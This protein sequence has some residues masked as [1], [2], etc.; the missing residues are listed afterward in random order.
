MLEGEV[1]KGIGL[2]G[3]PVAPC[4]D[5]AETFLPISG[6]A[7]TLHSDLPA[8]LI[9]GVASLFLQS[10]HPLAMAGVADHSDYRRDPLGRLQRTAN[11]VGTVTYASRAEAE[12]AIAKIRRIH[13]RVVGTA[14]DG[15]PYAATDGDLVTWVH[16]SEVSMF[17]AAAVAYGS[18]TYDK[19]FLDQYVAELCDQAELLGGTAVPRS[20]DELARYFTDIQGELQLGDQARDVRKFLLR[21]VAKRPQ[22]K[23]AYGV[24]V[25]AAIAILPKWARRELRLPLLPLAEPL[26]IRPAAFAFSTVLRLAIQPPPE[27]SVN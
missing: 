4:M 20:M 5:E 2:E 17:A 15:R 12:H 26:V 10:L 8:M 1:R 13:T 9:G 11:Y 19:A 27:L 25:A 18:R 7:R 14:P 16:A 24:V 3:E 22:D 6:A 21:G 23:L